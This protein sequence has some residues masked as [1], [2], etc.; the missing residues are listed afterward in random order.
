MNGAPLFVAL[1][2]EHMRDKGK[3]TVTT[4]LTLLDLHDLARS[5]RTFGVESLFVVHPSPSMRH[6]ARRVLDHWDAGPGAEYNPDRKEAFRVLRLVEDLDAVV[7]AIDLE[8]GMLPLLVATSAQA[9]PKSISFTQLREQLAQS[10]RPV[11][12]ML[13]TG[14]GMTPAL[15][16]RVDLLLEPICGTGSYNH[17]SVRSACAI[18]LDRLRTS[19]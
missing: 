9:G 17:L 12:L 15:L 13:G 19:F 8:H 11:L 4:S 6:L 1:L 18:M 5:A 14:G 3:R 10:T 16:E 7:H 2:H